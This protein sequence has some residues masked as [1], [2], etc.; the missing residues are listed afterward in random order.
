MPDSHFCIQIP[1]V[2]NSLTGNTRSPLCIS[3]QLAMFSRCM[4]N[5]NSSVYVLKGSFVLLWWL[6]IGFLSAFNKTFPQVS[7]CIIWFFC[8]N[9]LKPKKWLMKWLISKELC[10]SSNK[11]LSALRLSPH[12]QVLQTLVR[13]FIKF[14]HWA[15]N[16]FS[17]D[18]QARSQI[19]TH[20]K[21]GCQE[22]SH[23]SSVSN[24][25]HY[26]IQT[27]TIYQ[28]AFW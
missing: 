19:F 4:S 6:W 18:L 16:K 28:Q 8:S 7:T 14:T 22:T 11:T 2:P 5:S 24:W 3:R 27:L 26:Y 21:N 1:K 23:I 9:M 13:S 10:T 12:I 25:D 17:I 20:N 15:L